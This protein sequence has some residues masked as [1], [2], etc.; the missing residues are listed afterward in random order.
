MCTWSLLTRVLYKSNSLLLYK[1]SFHRGRK[2]FSFCFLL[3]FTHFHFFC[4]CFCPC[5]CLT[6]CFNSFTLSLSFKAS[7]VLLKLL[8]IYISHILLQVFHTFTF[9]S[10]SGVAQTGSYFHCF[11]VSLVHTFTFSSFSGF[12]QSAASLFVSHPASTP[13]S[14]HWFILS[15]VHIFTFLRF[16]G[17]AESVLP[18]IHLAS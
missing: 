12:T 11:A 2:P 9:L 1:S 7:P 17:F 3:N 4:L 14:L 6:S 5:I 16:S 13:G 15:L 18:C 10:I 8:P